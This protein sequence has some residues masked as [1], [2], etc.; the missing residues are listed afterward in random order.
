MCVLFCVQSQVR[1]CY[2]I[3][4]LAAIDIRNEK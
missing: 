2:E 1:R 3:F 4:K